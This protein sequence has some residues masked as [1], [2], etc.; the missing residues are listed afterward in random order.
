MTDGKEITG[1]ARQAVRIGFLGAG[2]VADVHQLALGEVPDGELVG[3]TDID[4]ELATAKARQWSVR[5]YS[6]SQ[7]LLADPAIDA[8]L[9]LTHTDSHIDLATRALQAG[10]HILVEKPVA[11]HAAEITKLDHLARSEG[12]VAMPGHNY[13]YVP[14]YTRIL[15][16][17]SRG[18]LGTIRA[19][20]VS[21]I[22]PHPEEI[23]AQYTG[24]LDEVMIHHTYLAA[25]ILGLPD[26]ITAGIS[27]PAWKRHTAEDQAWMAWDYASGA[28]AQLFCSFAMDDHSNSPATF[29]VKALGT[30]GT[31]VMDWRTAIFQRPLATLPYAVVPYEESYTRELAAF[32]DTIAGRPSIASTLADAAS[33]AT[34]LTAAHLSAHALRAVTR[35]EGGW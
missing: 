28:T 5:N 17:V 8:V 30:N 33:A 1:M 21:Y 9:V 22:I 15:R 2:R 20:F 19:V 16:L 7:A 10:K 18:D 26:R 13:V 11:N 12:L 23:A 6:D 24:V 14:E 35:A 31:A 4:A 29:I 3:L 32:C 27:P 34:I 25:G